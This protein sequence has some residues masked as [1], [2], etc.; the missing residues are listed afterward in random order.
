MNIT[1]LER[2][3]ATIHKTNQWLGELME[4]LDMHDKHRADLVMRTVPWAL[5]DRLPIAEV[6]ELVALFER[7]GSRGKANFADRVLSAMGHGIGGHVERPESG[8]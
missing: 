4:L 1:G 7:F 3:D 2:F 8:R 6:A 5:R